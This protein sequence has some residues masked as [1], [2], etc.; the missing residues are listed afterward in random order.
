MAKHAYVDLK[1]TA[2]EAPPPA[3]GARMPGTL[4][5]RLLTALEVAEFVG[6]HEETVRRGS[7]ANDAGRILRATSRPSVVSAAPYTSPIPPAP[8]RS[9]SRYRRGPSDA[10][11]VRLSPPAGDLEVPVL[12]R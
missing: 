10:A 8:S 2:L 6:C 3:G 1:E 11:S 4:P 9:R 5:N 7:A 12:K